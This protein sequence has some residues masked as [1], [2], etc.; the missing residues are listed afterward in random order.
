[1]AD[2]DELALD[3]NRRIDLDSANGYITERMESMATIRT[4]D[5]SMRAENLVWP[6][7]GPVSGDDHVTD[8][9]WNAIDYTC[10][11]HTAIAFA[12]QNH[13]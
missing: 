7:L 13:I 12:D 8:S 2:Q 3:Q 5:S 1:V 4:P 6:S 11:D 9:L 10:D